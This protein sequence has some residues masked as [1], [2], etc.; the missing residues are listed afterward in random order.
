[1]S[2][3]YNKKVTLSGSTSSLT[4]AAFLAT[5]IEVLSGAKSK[6][7]AENR[8]TYSNKIT[9]SGQITICSAS[10][11]GSN[12]YATRTPLRLNLSDF[13]GTL[14]AGA[15]YPADGR[16]TFD[17]SVGSDRFVLDIP[18]GIV[19]Q[20]SG[21]TLRIGQVTGTGS[22]GG[23]SSFANDGSYR[24]NT[25][26]VGNDG[27][28]TFDGGIIGGDSFEKMGSGTMT[29]SAAAASGK[30]TTTGNVTIR[31]GALYFANPTSGTGGI[32]GTGVLTIENGAMLYGRCGTSETIASNYPF[33]NS[34][35]IVNGKIH[36]GPMKIYYNS[37]MDFNGANV[38]FNQGSEM[39]MEA[40]LGT[41]KRCTQ[42]AN[43]GKLTINDGATISMLFYP[44]YNP[45]NSVTSVEKADS[46]I[47]FKA[48]TVEV[49][50]VNYQ[51][52]DL[53]QYSDHLYYDYS[54]IT[55]GIIKIRYREAT[56]IKP[57]GADEQV[58]V[59][60]IST[61]GVTMMTYKSKYSAVKSDFR[62]T[63]VPQGMYI[64]R[65]SND[66]GSRKTMTIKK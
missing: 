9:G 27:D 50:D 18:D 45:A 38:T 16:F 44:N 22:L 31:E 41:G 15:T 24:V 7:T 17:T 62:N 3:S 34:S 28:F 26:R 64:L 59:E 19:V 52:P 32:L 12:W 2:S 35:I 11:K 36:P 49:G 46:F 56:G 40:R 47:I 61:S 55:N 21:Q 51:L 65:V 1:M 66:K 25:W 48:T 43:I 6:L 37:Y 23:Y 8:V 14:V 39:A 33:K 58:T 4:G 63:P 53:S 10:E 57:I 60:V 42:L 13:A 54:N 29:V 5:P 30:W 20:N